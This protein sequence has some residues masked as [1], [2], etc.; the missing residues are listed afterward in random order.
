MVKFKFTNPIS[1]SHIVI[2]YYLDTSFV[3]MQS[4]AANIDYSVYVL[5]ALVFAT[6]IMLFKFTNSIWP[7]DHSEWWDIMIKTL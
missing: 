7:T 6:L 4:L 2:L 3:D 1:S 5:S